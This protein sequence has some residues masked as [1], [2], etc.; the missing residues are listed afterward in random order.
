MTTR[1]VVRVPPE[2][3]FSLLSSPYC[4]QKTR[5]CGPRRYA[6][7]HRRIAI[8]FA[9][10]NGPDTPKPSYEEIDAQPLNSVVYQLFRNKM[11]AALG[12]SD[13]SM[14]G[15][16][17]IVDLTRRLNSLGS[18]RETQVLTRQILNS[19]FPSWLPPAFKV[20]FARPLPDISCRLNAFA[21]WLTCQWLMGECEINAVE[22]DGGVV[23][24]GY[25][26]LVK[27]CRY[28]EETGCVGVC[29][30]SCKIPTQEF[31]EK[32]M[33]LPLTM[34]PNYETFECQFSFGKT[35]LPV[36]EDEAFRSSC[37][38]QCPTRHR[39]RGNDETI[40]PRIFDM[41]EKSGVNQ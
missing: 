32:D 24:E 29:V 30:N 37:F 6:S 41:E 22:V 8:S 4:H 18:P 7:R 10:K 13:S 31:F 33:G 5:S 35:P 26:V 20:M 1:G 12:N 27:R 21:T 11:V 15:Y 36:E 16:D 38:S 17:G 23:K 39:S 25:G 3:V 14:P 9:L 19:L 34:E 40:C 2:T 28:L